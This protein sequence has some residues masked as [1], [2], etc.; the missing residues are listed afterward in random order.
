[1]ISWLARTLVL[2][3]AIRFSRATS[4]PSAVIEIEQFSTALIATRKG[5]GAAGFAAALRVGTGTGAA[6]RD[7]EFPAEAVTLDFAGSVG[8]DVTADVAGLGNV[9]LAAFAAE[10]L[11]CAEAE[12]TGSGSWLWTVI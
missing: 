4:W 9:C 8:T 3:G 2:A 12:F 1:M 5:G 10:L 11:S 7:G 6:A